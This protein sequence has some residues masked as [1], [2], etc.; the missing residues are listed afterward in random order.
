LSTIYTLL[1]EVHSTGHVSPAKK[2]KHEERIILDDHANYLIRKTVHDFFF[3]QIPPT[4]D[5]V[6]EETK[7]NPEIPKMGRSKL[8]KVLKELQFFQRQLCSYY[9]DPAA[10]QFCRRTYT[11]TDITIK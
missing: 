7:L 4:I 6:H 11:I 2:A 9:T 3:K 5:A 1:G 8:H 10:R